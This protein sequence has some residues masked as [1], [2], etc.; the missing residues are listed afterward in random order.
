MTVSRMFFTA[1]LG[2]TLCVSS[3]WGFGPYRFGQQPSEVIVVEQ[4]A[5]LR[6]VPSTPQ[7][8]STPQAPGMPKGEVLRP[9]AAQ[10][11]VTDAF[12]Q[13]PE[14]GTEA[15]AS[16]NPQM[17]GDFIGGSACIVNPVFATTGSTY[18]S[19]TV[20]QP[21]A[22]RG[23]Y[24]IADNESPR[25]VNR[26]F[27][28]YNYFNDVNGR[29]NGPDIPRIDVHRETFGFERTFLEG[30]ASFGIRVP[31]IQQTNSG[32]LDF[33]DVGDL[34][35]ILKYAFINDYFTGN[36]AS[37]GLVVTVPTGP[38]YVLVDGTTLDPVL[39]QPW[40]GF[41]WNSG[42]VYV[43]GFSS[44][45]VPTQGVDAVVLF[46]DL[47]VGFRAWDDAGSFITSI[48]PTLEGHITTPLANRGFDEC[49]VRYQDVV[50]ITG[51]LHLGLGER[52]LLTFGAA[53]PLTGAK[54]FSVEGIVQ[55]NY[56]Y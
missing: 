30:D 16:F 45:V 1:G 14:A 52:S 36:V 31:L 33:S 26:V 56:R 17:L 35:F 54:P 3:A 20:R 28:S 49:G 40:A 6:P 39:I 18:S 13:A 50:V 53:T 8:P 44:V 48:T 32:A 27:F 10:P 24:K 29:I 51:G 22:G 23:G 12:S 47:G 11:P 41:V 5:M 43:H 4:P 46:N 15:P 55:L 19:R 25:P 34:S 21:L 2:L 9:D 42:A 37:A 7:M 38:D